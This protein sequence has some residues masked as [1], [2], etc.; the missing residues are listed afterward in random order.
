MR[1]IRLGKRIGVVPT[2]M[3]LGGRLFIVPLPVRRDPV[4]WVP[5]RPKPRHRPRHLPVRLA[6]TRTQLNA[7]NSTTNSTA[8]DTGTV[9]P[10]ASSFCVILVRT[11]YTTA[12]APTVTFS[13]GTGLTL[14]AW[15]NVKQV[16]W[17]TAASPTDTCAI[18]ASLTGATPGSGPVHVAISKTCSG[19]IWEV[20]QLDGCDLSGGTVASVTVQT[21][22]GSSDTAGTT[23][24][25]TF[26][27]AVNTANAVTAAGGINSSAAP[28]PTWNN[29]FTGDVN[30]GSGEGTA[31]DLGTGHVLSG[32]TGSSHTV[33]A[34]SGIWGVCGVEWKATAAVA[35]VPYDL[36]HSPQFQSFIAT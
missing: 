31:Y 24:T 8:Y 14:T 4:R 12:G 17:N 28:G 27:G 3:V 34:T 21:G 29:G 22:S 23:W 18:G 35:Y 1:R 25:D 15:S 36:E 5:R 7:S 32:F 33:T 19:L 16:N 9:T 6:I 30:S 26:G 13:N 2:P 20:L 10:S 11:H